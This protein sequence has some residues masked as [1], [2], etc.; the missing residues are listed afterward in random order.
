MENVN[1]LM[2]GLDFDLTEIFKS[3]TDFLEMIRNDVMNQ[4]MTGLVM[5]LFSCFPEE[6]RVFMIVVILLAIVLVLYSL[7]RTGGV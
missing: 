4:E 7:F 5:Y 6:L 1:D 3:I 2:N